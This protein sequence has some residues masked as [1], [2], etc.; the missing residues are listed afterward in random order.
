MHAKLEVNL[1]QQ[2]NLWHRAFDRLLQ[3][4]STGVLE[5]EIL[6]AKEIFFS[7]LG[8]AHE[9]KEE[10]YE[11]AS[12]SF[13]EWYLFNYRTKVFLKSPAVTYLTL[14]QGDAEERLVLHRSLF[15]HWSLFE[16]LEIEKDRILLNDL[17]F[18]RQRVVIYDSEAPEARLWQV[19]LGNIL[20]ARL[21]LFNE[22]NQNEEVYF[23]THLWIHP[24][25]ENETLKKICVHRMVLWTRHTEFLLAAFEAVVRTHGIQSQITSSRAHNWMYQELSKRYG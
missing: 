25:S 24:A 2:K 18:S 15:D 8:R 19:K 4:A 21:F 13:I 14:E 20:Q 5:K 1:P 10:L 12:Q 23:F 16:V 7:K 6:Q 17:L 9:M 11:T 22:D 3:F